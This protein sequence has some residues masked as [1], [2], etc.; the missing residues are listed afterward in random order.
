MR[1]RDGWTGKAVWD[2]FR[3][4]TGINELTWLTIEKPP[5][6]SWTDVSWSGARRHVERIIRRESLKRKGGRR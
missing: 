4:G 5:R 6:T 1:L 3:N 2:C